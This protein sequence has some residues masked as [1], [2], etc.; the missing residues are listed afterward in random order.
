VSTHDLTWYI[1]IIVTI[2]LIVVL[3]GSRWG[4]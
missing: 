4:R 3:I 1:A 2:T